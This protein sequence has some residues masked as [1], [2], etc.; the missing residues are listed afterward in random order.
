MGLVS[1][2]SEYVKVEYFWSRCASSGPYRL[3]RATGRLLLRRGEEDSRPWVDRKVSL[4]SPL[5]RTAWV[6]I[7]VLDL[8]WQYLIR[9]R[10]PLLRGRVV[11]CDRYAW[12]AAAELEASLA[13]RDRAS[14]LAVRLLLALSPR[15]NISFLLRAPDPVLAQRK[16]EQTDPRYLSALTEAYQRLAQA[17]LF[18]VKD[19]GGDFTPLSDDIARE[20]LAIYLEDY[21]TA[22]GGL[23]F[24]NPSQFNPRREGK[25]L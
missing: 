24:S 12:D 6:Y 9:V 22:L 4:S 7:V 8:L 2:I 15:P 14:R 5:R 3:L 20:T 1:A 10:L 23:F 21:R 18:R 19:T 11:V 25:R 17:Y 16:Q 13:P